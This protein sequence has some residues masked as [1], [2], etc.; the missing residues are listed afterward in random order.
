MVNLPRLDGRRALVTGANSGIGYPTARELARAGAS[1]VLACRK[2]ELGQAAVSR[3]RSEVPGADVTFRPLDL[4]SL[5]SVGRLAESVEGPLHLLVN[6]AGVMAP[7]RWSATEDGFELQFGVNH[8]GHFA[9]T[10]R[11]LPQLLDA[12]DARVVT[13]ASLA[14]RSGGREVLLGNPVAGYVPSRA[15]GNSKLANLL[16]GAEL[17]RRASGRLVSTMAHPGISA[18]NLFLS[19]EGMGA[20]PVVRIGGRLVGRL[21]F[22]SAAAGAQPTLVAATTAEPGSYTGPRWPGEFRGAPA[23]AARSALAADPELAALLWQLSQEWTGVS[24]DW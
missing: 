23:P 13:V 14:H 18:T 19:R 4:A 1:V 11:L 8:L 21:L 16:F 6:N 12:G 20:N 15:Y 3:L 24:Y 7:P 5:A 17:Q 9:L 10:G 22:Q 2:P